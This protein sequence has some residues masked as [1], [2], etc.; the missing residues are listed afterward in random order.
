VAEISLVFK[1]NP[2]QLD[3][4]VVDATLKAT[5]GLKADVTDHTLDDGSDSADGIIKKNPEFRLSGVITARNSDGRATDAYAKLEALLGKPITVVTSI[6]KYE[7]MVMNTLDVDQDA[8]AGGV[9]PFSA[10]FKGIRYARSQEIE[11]IDDPRVKK[12]PN[13]GNQP[14]K[15]ASEPVKNQSVAKKGILK[16]TDALKVYS[17]G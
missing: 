10:S 6:K 3:T 2:T 7:N 11:L 15:P 13:K 9:V 16:I 5:H 8:R 4:L 14:T 17:K 1:A 12:K